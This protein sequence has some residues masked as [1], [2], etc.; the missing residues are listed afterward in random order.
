VNERTFRAG[1]ALK[2][3][4]PERLKWLPP[5][6]VIDAIGLRAGMAVVDLGAGTGYFSIP[7]AEAVGVTGRV[8]AV[9][10]QKGM[11]D[12]LREKIAKRGGPG[13]IA[14]VLGEAAKTT[15][16]EATADLV[17]MANVWHEVDDRPAVLAEMKRLLLPGGV[18]AILDWRAD[19]EPPPGPPAGHRI[20]AGEVGTDLTGEGWAV[21]GTRNVGEYHYL[22]LSRPG[23]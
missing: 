12:F 10:L 13:N 23:R 9:D 22:V 7:I 4:D 11:L 1:N 18:L 17:L 15:L 20:T 5:A 6:E 21:S 2:L 19:R 14:L 16:P 3:E 8:T